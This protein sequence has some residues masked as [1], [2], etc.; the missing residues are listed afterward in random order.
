MTSTARSGAPRPQRR[1]ND[2]EYRQLADFRY[3]I[4][5]FME[6]SEQAARNAGLTPQQH[7]AL[8]AVRGLMIDGNANLGTLAERLRLAAMILGD[9]SETAAP[10]LDYSDTWTDED[11]RDLAAHSLAYAESLYPEEA[12]V[13]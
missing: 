1:L 2:A 10:T 13:A 11:V 6:F 7:Q 9:L 5:S 4:R 3:A 8:L 12:E